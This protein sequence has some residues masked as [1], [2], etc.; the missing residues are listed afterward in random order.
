MGR[1]VMRRVHLILCILNVWD[2]LMQLSAWTVR[3]S[4]TYEIFVDIYRFSFPVDRSSD[5]LFFID[6]I[7]RKQTHHWPDIHTQPGNMDIWNT[8]RGG[9]G[10]NQLHI[11]FDLDSV[12]IV[13][14]DRGLTFKLG[15]GC[16]DF[17]L[18]QLKPCEQL[19]VLHMALL[20]SPF[21]SHWCQG[22]LLPQW[23]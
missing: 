9:S 1:W 2:L 23:V 12:C 3:L 22:A 8:G 4:R 11:I 21:C 7:F 17:K 18:D 15:F 6:S 5:G 20:T 19:N 16:R 10:D 13:L 14:G